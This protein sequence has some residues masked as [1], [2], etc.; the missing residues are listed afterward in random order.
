MDRTKISTGDGIP[1]SMLDAPADSWRRRRA[2]HL[3]E[4]RR[5]EEA[6]REH[7][8]AVDAMKALYKQ[9]FDIIFEEIR[10]SVKK[11]PEHMR[12]LKKLKV[13]ED[14]SRKLVADNFTYFSEKRKKIFQEMERRGT[15]GD[16]PLPVAFVTEQK[17]YIQHR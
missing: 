4:R 7:H 9:E 14:K 3:E 15:F 5:A 13:V 2:V 1:D 6:I 17:V 10:K 12:L 8:K 11:S 16:A